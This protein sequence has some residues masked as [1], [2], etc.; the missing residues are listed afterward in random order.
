MSTAVK[1]SHPTAALTVLLPVHNEANSIEPVLREL[2]HRVAQPYGARFLVCEDGSTDGTS[3]LLARLAPEMGFALES[4]P[5]RRGYADAVRN[6]LNLTKSPFVF[7]TD[8]DG[9]YDPADFDVLWKEI[10][11]CDMAIGRKLDRR[12][13]YYRTLLSGGFHLLI[14]AFAGVPLQDMDCGFRLIRKE[15]IEAVLPDVQSLPYSFWAEFSILAYRRG[16]RVQEVPVSHRPRLHGSSSIYAWNRIPRILI[17]QFLGLLRLA[18]RLNRE[19]AT[20]A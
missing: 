8:S 16:F 5:D 12:E 19:R 4:H 9:Q 3:N 7:F 1:S 2:N 13:S 17:A 11:S 14:K 10:A 15:V 20:S 6:G 18:R